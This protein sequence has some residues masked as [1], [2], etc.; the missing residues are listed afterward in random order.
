[1]TAVSKLAI[2]VVWLD[3]EEEYLKEGAEPASFV[4]RARAEEMK[5]FMLEGMSDE[6]QSINVVPYPHRTTNSGDR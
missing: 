5:S 6:V 3:G 4:N 2:K 1:M